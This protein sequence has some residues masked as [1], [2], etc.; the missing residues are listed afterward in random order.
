MRACVRAVCFVEMRGGGCEHEHEHEQ[1]Q[2][3]AEH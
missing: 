3:N 1:E 2:K